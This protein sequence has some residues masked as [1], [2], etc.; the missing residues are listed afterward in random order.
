MWIKEGPLET[1]LSQFLFK[2]RITPH[3]ST[4]VSPAELIFGRTLRSRLD[5]IYSDIGRKM[6]QQ[7]VN[8]HGHHLRTFQPDDKVYSRNFSSK[9]PKWIPAVIKQ[10][11]GPVS[12]T[13]I[14]PDGRLIKRH[15]DHILSRECSPNYSDHDFDDFQYSVHGSTIPQP[16]N[17]STA[18]PRR[19]TR[20]RRPPDRYSP[21]KN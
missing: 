12:Y 4:G 1:R 5:L 8:N 6:N 2:Y 11:I 10:K 7:K 18:E 16:S 20:F 3:S 9:E 15:V 13:I 19:T 14:L 21:S 17:G